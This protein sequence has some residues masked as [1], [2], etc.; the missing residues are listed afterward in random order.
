MRS[1][2]V[3]SHWLLAAALAAAALLTRFYGLGDWPIYRD[4]KFTI[5]HAAERA[6]SLINPAYYS[7]VLASLELPL[8]IETAARLPAAVL[9]VLGVPAL[10]LF[11]TPAIGRRAAALA[12]VLLLLSPWHLFHSQ[13]ARFYS[14]VVL[15]AI[16]ACALYYRALAT[17]SVPRFAIA[18]ALAAGAALFHATAVTLLAGFYLW[19]VALAATG[20]AG[21][22]AGNRLARIAAWGG[23]VPLLGVGVLLAPLARDWIGLGQ[24]WQVSPVRFAGRLAFD[25]EL[26]LAA[27]AALG[28]LRA[29]RLRMPVGF[30]L[31]AM[32]AATAGL[33][34][35]ATAVF[36][37]RTDYAIAALPLA[38]IGAALL[39][40]PGE[41]D[42]SGARARWLEHAVAVLLVVPLLPAFASHYLERRTLDARE[43]VA[44]V[45]A[46]RAPGD[47][48]Y[49]YS[50]AYDYYVGDGTALLPYIGHP[51]LHSGRW[52]P[53]LNRYLNGAERVWLLLRRTGD[54]LAA[55]L[56]HWLTTHAR[57]AWRQYAERYDRRIEGFEIYLAERPDARLEPD[58]CGVE[59]AAAEPAE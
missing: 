18:I 44:F 20:R 58:G 33:P 49:N 12:A 17:G 48:V 9:G 53:C 47:R 52:E 51:V 39:L 45:E 11:W 3:A 30:Y 13:Y 29:V 10:Y 28:V 40:V 42:A 43:V 19:A 27:A 1:A 38:C 54:P 34:L 22:P 56:E 15:L 59:R 26:V 24:G 41:R 32:L 23:I 25:L 14:G 37:M 21:S 35:A 36:D 16:V 46:R 31:L 6:A 55:D 50:T 2:D 4:E 5:L 57:L 8:G 7:L